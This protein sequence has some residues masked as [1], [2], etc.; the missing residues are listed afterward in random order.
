M[1]Q[2]KETETAVGRCEA[3]AVVQGSWREAFDAKCVDFGFLNAKYKDALK[4]I[5]Q[6]RAELRAQKKETE[7]ALARYDGLEAAMGTLKLQFHCNC[8]NFDSLNAKYKEAQ[9]ELTRLRPELAVKCEELQQVNS[10]F[11]IWKTQAEK[12]GREKKLKM[13]SI[14]TERDQLSI[15]LHKLQNDMENENIWKTKTKILRRST[16]G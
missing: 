3:L 4:D 16:V 11:T 1:A 10:R 9:T 6:L 12:K 2:R 7:A 14:T 5:T 15:Q 8:V 13:V